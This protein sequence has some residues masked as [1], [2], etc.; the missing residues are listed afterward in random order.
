MTERLFPNIASLCIPPDASIRQAME[1]VDRH[2][3]GIV[4]VVDREGRLTATVTDGDV[5]R[6]ILGGHGLS[7]PVTVLA[8]YSGRGS[9]IPLTAPEGT[10]TA[11]LLEMMTESGVHQMPLV[12]REGRVV[13]LALLKQLSREP[14]LP[15]SAVIMAGGY[16]R[17]LLPL[18]EDCPKPML[19]V[20]GRPLLEIT[21]ERLRRSG[22]RS[23]NITTHYLARQISDHF[24]D[25]SRFG[26]DIRYVEESRPLG[27][28]GALA[29]LDRCTEPLLVINGDVV[30]DLDFGAMR[31][32]HAEH[33]AAATIAVAQHQFQISYGVV[34]HDGPYARRVVE[35]PVMRHL[36]NAGIYLIEPDAQAYV[37]RDALFNMTDLIDRMIEAGERVVVFPVREYWIDVGQPGDYHRVQR[38][39]SDGVIKAMAD[40]D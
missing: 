13:D 29:L 36:V 8:D 35:K 40:G 16:G 10:S 32:F 24:G 34:E 4:L 15:M 37:P 1:L 11:A 18:T 21:L 12:D 27:T 22:I 38:D 25:G 6:A 17:R 28:A 14:P 26:M 9:P 30:T 23:V 20:G 19:P 5:R 31:R 39:V 33:E 2:G 3:T 7:D